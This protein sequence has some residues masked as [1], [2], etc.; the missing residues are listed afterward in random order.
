MFVTSKAEIERTRRLLG[1][2]YFQDSGPSGCLA[3]EESSADGVIARAFLYAGFFE[4]E[5]RRY[6]FVTSLAI[7]VLVLLVLWSNCLWLLLL[8]PLSVV[9]IWQNLRIKSLFRAKSFESDYTAMLLA[10]SSAIRT[11]MD[12]LVALCVSAK[13]F[14]E[15]SEIRKEIE[16]IN[17]KLEAGDSE[18]LALS[19]FG[20]TI[21]HPDI[22]LFTT[23]FILARKEGSSLAE[24][25]QRLVRVTRQRQSF[26]R[27]IRSAVAMQKLS[28]FGI[29][30]CSLAIGGIQAAMNS[31]ALITAI[32]HPFGLKAICFGIALMGI[33][34][35]WMLQMTKSRI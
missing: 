27:K 31:Q 35:G 24:C 14:P 7:G 2:D 13:L 18:E 6:L 12:P 26:R 1:N 32:N 33:G 22:R 30:G 21:E 8:A 16:T 23:A 19:G 17:I 9:T 5:R 34:L 28:S 29:I 20:A 3:K 25:L 4:E 11:G 15:K 10:V